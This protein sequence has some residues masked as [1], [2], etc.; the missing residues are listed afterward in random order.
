MARNYVFG[1]AKAQVLMPS[2]YFRI[3]LF[4]LYLLSHHTHSPS[5]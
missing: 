3:K 5:F 1:Q 4:A 2:I